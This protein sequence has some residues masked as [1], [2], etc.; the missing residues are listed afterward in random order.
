MS[1]CC[2]CRTGATGGCGRRNGGKP[3]LG[4]PPGPRGKG[5]PLP[6][7]FLNLVLIRKSSSFSLCRKM[8][9]IVERTAMISMIRIQS[10]QDEPGSV[11]FVRQQVSVLSH[12]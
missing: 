12:E 10:H 3:G 5:P 9:P 11:V 4:G 8:N 2:C 6:L 1:L 7:S